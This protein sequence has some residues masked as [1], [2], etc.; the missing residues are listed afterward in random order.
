VELPDF[1][2]AR[3]EAVRCLGEMLSDRTAQFWRDGEWRIEVKDYT[4]LILT[5]LIVVAVNA[6]AAP[7]LR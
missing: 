2:S 6:A 1:E 3:I 7:A 5:T 4:G